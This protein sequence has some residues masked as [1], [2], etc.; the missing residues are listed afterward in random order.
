MG[1][2]IHLFIEGKIDDEWVLLMQPDSGRDYNFFSALSGVRGTGEH[3]FPELYGRS[4]PNDLSVDVKQYMLG[5]DGELQE[6]LHSGGWLSYEQTELFFQKYETTNYDTAEIVK[7][8][9]RSWLF[10][11]QRTLDIMSVFKES[12]AV[13]DV[14]IIFCYDS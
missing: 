14:R 2:D 7:E 9:A 10:W 6:G 12:G 5:E 4:L 3:I 13:E 1:T 8:R 11:K